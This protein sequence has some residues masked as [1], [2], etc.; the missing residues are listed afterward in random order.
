LYAQTKKNKE[1]IH[2]FPLAGRSLDIFRKA[3]LH[4]V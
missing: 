3:G 1:L 4:P 2:Y